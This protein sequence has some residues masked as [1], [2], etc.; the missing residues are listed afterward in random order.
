MTSGKE[1]ENK[2][3]SMKIYALQAVD[4][5]WEDPAAISCD[6][7]ALKGWAEKQDY[8]Y[9]VYIVEGEEIAPGIFQ[10]KYDGNI[11]CELDHEE[12]KWRS[13]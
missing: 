2:E 3:Q 11:I 5:G 12:R 8:D 7:N 13:T 10:A 4:A 1:S 9:P 6:L